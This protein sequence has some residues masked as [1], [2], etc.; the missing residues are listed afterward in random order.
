MGPS[1]T[2][3]RSSSESLNPI[4]RATRTRSGTGRL[5]LAGKGLPVGF[6]VAQGIPRIAVNTL[7]AVGRANRLRVGFPCHRGC[8]EGAT[9]GAREA[10]RRVARLGNVTYVRVAEKGGGPPTK[11]GGGGGWYQENAG[12]HRIGPCGL[13]ATRL[14]KGAKGP[15]GRRA[16]WL[17]LG[18]G[19]TVQ[20]GD[21]PTGWPGTGRRGMGQ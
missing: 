9:S 17:H 3:K 15:S 6:D 14:V 13:L 8:S 12:L 20:R 21:R 2:P 7:N 1:S 16:N 19:L 5:G 18:G 11:E 10:G 4:E